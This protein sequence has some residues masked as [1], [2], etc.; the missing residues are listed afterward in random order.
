MNEPIGRLGV[1]ALDCPDPRELAEFYRPI[2]GGEI[3]V[4]EDGDWVELQTDRGIIAFQRI[5]DHRPPTWPSGDV[6]QQAHIDVVVDQLDRCEALVLELGAV[7]AD[8]Q[9]SH[10]DF[11][12]F[13]DPAGHPFCLVH[14]AHL[15]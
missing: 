5:D 13:F 9:P 3:A 12:V 2:V 7:K 11:R 14:D 15:S 4:H 1:F 8:T 10:S 6:P